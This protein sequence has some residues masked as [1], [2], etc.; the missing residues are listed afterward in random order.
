MRVWVTGLLYSK[1]SLFAGNGFKEIL[2]KVKKSKKISM[3]IFATD[4]DHEAIEKAR[5]GI[6]PKSI[7]DDVSSERLSRFFN[8]EGES[9][10]INSSIREMVVFAPHNVIKDPPFTKLDILTCRNML[11]YM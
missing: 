6:F 5:K 3:Q 1:K 7:S 8:V 2:D 9:Y 10:R 11:I 4:I